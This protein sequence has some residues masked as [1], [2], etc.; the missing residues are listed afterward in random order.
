MNQSLQSDAVG[1]IIPGL[2]ADRQWVEKVRD[3][4]LQPFVFFLPAATT[5]R[6]DRLIESV[7]NDLGENARC[8]LRQGFGLGDRELLW[9]RPGFIPAWECR[10]KRME[11]MSIHGQE[12][13]SGNPVRKPKDGFL[14][15]M[16]PSSWTH[17]RRTSSRRTH[18]RRI[19][20]SRTN[21]NRTHAHQNHGR[22]TGSR[23]TDARQT[24][25]R[26][27]HARR[28]SARRTNSCPATGWM[29][30]SHPRI[31]PAG[32]T[33]TGQTPAVHTQTGPTPA[34]P[35]P[36]RQSPAGPT[37]AGQSRTG[38]TT[39]QPQDGGHR[40]TPK[41]GFLILMCPPSC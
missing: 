19:H 40:L 23:R 9:R 16:C 41:D 26:R 5:G 13:Q 15:L 11:L 12:T 38:R 32:H 30:S 1:Q 36:A 24:S 25:A 29:S 39:S 27:T 10:E 18:G 3:Y 2:C 14:I 20:A 4:P 34:G 28:T 17:G 35:T 33:R 8:T 37:P 21:A 22:R 7:P 31:T 6:G